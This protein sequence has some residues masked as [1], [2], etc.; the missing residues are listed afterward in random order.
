MGE[1]EFLEDFSKRVAITLS[2]FIGQENT[3]ETRNELAERVD[4]M[5]DDHEFLSDMIERIG[6]A[7]VHSIVRS[8]GLAMTDAMLDMEREGL[9]TGLLNTTDSSD[10]IITISGLVSG[11]DTNLNNDSYMYTLSDVLIDSSTTTTNGSG[12]DALVDS[13]TFSVASSGGIY[14]APGGVGSTIS[15]GYTD[16]SNRMENTITINDPDEGVFKI[17]IHGTITSQDGQ[18]VN[19][20]DMQKKIDRMEEQISVLLAMIP[21]KLGNRILRSKNEM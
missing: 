14:T 13:T 5:L 15:T 19:I 6:E 2:G 10:D 11:V 21:K 3:A 4:K 12:V 7:E 9:D 17:D 8:T 1:D 20:F 16:W 18:E